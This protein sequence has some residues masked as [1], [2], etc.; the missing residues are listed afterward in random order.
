MHP[1]FKGFQSSEQIVKQRV[2]MHNLLIALIIHLFIQRTYMS[3]FLLLDQL[4]ISVVTTIFKI[5]LAI[6][7]S[8]EL[9]L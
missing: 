5:K 6:I 7:I 2:N 4:D 3:H 1:C 8:N 9:F